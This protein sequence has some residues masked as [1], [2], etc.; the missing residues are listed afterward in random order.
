MSIE[1]DT[2]T[3]SKILFASSNKSKYE[4][5][6]SILSK[7]G[8][9][10]KFFRCELQEIQADT[11]EQVAIHKVQDAFSQCCE[12]VIVEDNGLFIN[13]L[14]GFPGPYSSFTFKTIGTEGILNLVKKKRQA[15]FRSV[16]VYCQRN[17][18]AVLF[19]AKV[20]GKISRKPVGSKWG[21]DPIFIP[22]GQT[23]TYAQLKNKNL[24][25]HRYLALKKFA[26]WYLH[27]LESSDR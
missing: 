12:P 14:N 18:S 4:E 26:N 8:I 23:K 9:N 21:Y 2:Q 7:F 11:L 27:K 5:V 6:S 3:L 19:D 20:Q 22:S 1:G 24:F 17:R 25:S 15:T 10:L 16:I 13:S